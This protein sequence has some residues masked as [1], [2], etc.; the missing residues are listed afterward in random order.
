MYQRQIIAVAKLTMQGRQPL[1]GPLV[2]DIECYFTIPKSWPKYKKYE[3]AIGYRRPT[4]K[5]LG[6]VDNFMKGVLDSCNGIV[7]VDD[8][9]IVDGRLKKYYSSTAPYIKVLVQELP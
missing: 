8:S 5:N 4:S 2:V 3:A 9:Q 6:D 1:A 7:F